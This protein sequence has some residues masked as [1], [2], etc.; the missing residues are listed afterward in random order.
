MERKTEI[1]RERERNCV[2]R[3]CWQTRYLPRRVLSLPRS[4]TK[5]CNLLSYKCV[6]TARVT[7]LL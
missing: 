1:E 3:W 5:V 6:A 2:G 4:L 7:C